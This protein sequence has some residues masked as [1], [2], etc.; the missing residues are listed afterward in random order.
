MNKKSTQERAQMLQLLV[1]GNSLRAVSRITGASVNTVT[2]LLVEVGE[3][4]AWYQDKHLRNLPLKRVQMDEIWSF[5]Y[6]KAKNVPEEKEGQAGD[7][8]TW[9]A[10]DAETKLVPSWLVGDRSA[11]TAQ[12][13]V[14]DLATRMA[15][16]IQLT[17]DGH[18]AYLNAV[19]NAFGNDVD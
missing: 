12:A 9:T 3:A 6:A 16:R 10:I 2:K 19:E 4:C 1:E 5:V 15:N 11:R 14:N 18:K 8:W 7:V 13:F 17:S